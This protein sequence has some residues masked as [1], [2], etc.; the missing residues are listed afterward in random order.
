MRQSTSARI[1][2]EEFFSILDAFADEKFSKE[3]LAFEANLDNWVNEISELY[4]I[5]SLINFLGEIFLRIK[6]RRKAA[7]T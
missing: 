4:Q 1:G 2:L 6:F 7:C 5:P 3:D